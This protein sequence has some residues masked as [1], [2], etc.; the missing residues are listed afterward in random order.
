MIGMLLLYLTACG[1]DDASR[2]QAPSVQLAVVDRKLVKLEDGKVT[3]ITRME[4][5]SR[6]GLTERQC[7]L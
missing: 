5:G 2:L 6:S 3:V 7:R 1:G 4:A